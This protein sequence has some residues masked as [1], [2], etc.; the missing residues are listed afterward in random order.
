MPKPDAVIR[1]ELSALT[2]AG[3]QVLPG[4]SEISFTHV[5]SFEIPTRSTSCPLFVSVVRLRLRF[6]FDSYVPHSVYKKR[7]QMFTF[8]KMAGKF[9]R[10]H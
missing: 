1:N 5:I 9:R 6:V 3:V 8:L 4:T 2:A 7:F 10:L